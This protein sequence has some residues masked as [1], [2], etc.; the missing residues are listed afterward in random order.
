M[1][2]ETKAG[3]P[4]ETLAAALALAYVIERPNEKFV[5]DIQKNRMVDAKLG[6]ATYE[7]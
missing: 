6:K 2:I 3:N 7:R 5:E 4:I 1:G